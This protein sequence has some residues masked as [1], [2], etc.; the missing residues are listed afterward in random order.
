MIK[1]SISFVCCLLPVGAGAV[2]VNPESWSAVSTEQSAWQDAVAANDSIVISGAGVN[3]ITTQNGFAVNNMFVGDAV[4]Q[5]GELN[6]YVL[7]TVVNPFSVVVDTSVSN[8]PAVSLGAL[9][10][11]LNDKTL[12]ARCKV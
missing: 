6:L 4:A 1:E 2:V 9:L 12:G 5:G 11:V 8:T 3:G 10:Q 7:D